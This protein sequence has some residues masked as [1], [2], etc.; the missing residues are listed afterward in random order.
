[1][2]LK[3]RKGKLIEVS[4]WSI[5]QVRPKETS[6]PEKRLPCSAFM[7]DDSDQGCIIETQVHEL[8]DGS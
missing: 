4:L 5:Y 6:S 2:S 8:P 7:F 3:D 1:M